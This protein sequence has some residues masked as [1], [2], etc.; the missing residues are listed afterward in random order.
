M[1]KPELLATCWTTAG[2]TKPLSSDERSPEQLVDR[3][4][5][6]A[7]AGFTG[8]GLGY[9]DIIDLRDTIGFDQMSS[10]FAQHGIK[11]VE[12][13]MLMDWYERGEART[14]GNRFRDDLFEAASALNAVH[15]KAGCDYSG[16]DW[17][18]DTLAK[19]FRELCERAA[20]AGTRI[21]LEFQPMTSL[22]TVQ[23]A[24]EVV[25]T[26]DHPAGGLIVDI[27]HMERGNVPLETL[28]SIPIEAIFAT[29]LDDASSKMVGT[30]ME[31]TANHRKFCGDGDF[32]LKG[33]IQTLL[34]MEYDG[35]WG[36]EI[37]SEDFRKLPLV[38]AVQRAYST[39]MAQFEY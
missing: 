27:W 23:A 25:E 21:A 30:L 13:E 2:A 9:D 15:V 1:P 6:A 34:E 7:N 4:A 17:P 24:Y 22:K 39:T 28:K 14:K 8:F 33:F 32:N 29:E 16:R 31:D 35:P 12:L 38:S 19:D 11:Y 36:V 18:L 5:A 37:I 3:V 26:A 10:I 20:D